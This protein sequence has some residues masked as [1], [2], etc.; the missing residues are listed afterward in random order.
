MTL[1]FKKILNRTLALKLVLNL[2]KSSIVIL[3]L[4]A[5]GHAIAATVSVATAPLV[6]A[7]TTQVLPNLMYILDNSG[8]MASEFMP[9]YVTDGNKCKTTGT[10]GEFSASCGLGD[11][12]FHTNLFN[13][14][15]YNPTITYLPASNANGT[16]RIS[17]DSTNTAG[18]TNVP[19]DAYGVY[20]K[21]ISY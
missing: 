1:T 15:A 10:S 20:S 4:F 6:S 17:M 3:S 13:T 11:P 14:L 8:S 7:T 2:T 18:W 5:A 21:F 19:R 9:D 12:P 16:N